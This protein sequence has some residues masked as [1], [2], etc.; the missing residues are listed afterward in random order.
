MRTANDET[1]RNARRRWQV[2]LAGL[3]LVV[4]LPRLF[5][6][7]LAFPHHES[8]AGSEVWSVGPMRRAD[9]ERI[10]AESARRVGHSPLARES[11]P[12]RIFLT[13]GGWRWNWLA[14]N[15]RGALAISIPLGEAIVV[16]A[17][18]PASDRVHGAA[19][20]RRR[21]LTGIIAHE[22]CHGMVRREI[23]QLQAL[24]A[25][26]WLVEGYC[27]HVA[28]ESTL[29][30]ADAARLQ[31]AGKDHPALTYFLGRQRVER[32]LAANGG[33]VRAL[34]ADPPRD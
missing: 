17:N 20:G 33:D 30:A 27:D 19:F 13:D 9:I 23:G 5:P 32:A 3:A 6:Q 1:R 2:G 34:F 15:S 25:P 31:A 12:R 28:G 7:A 16:N 21:T 14:L 11:E 29:T 8:V 22:T 26:G 10:L 24:M 18:D 4:F